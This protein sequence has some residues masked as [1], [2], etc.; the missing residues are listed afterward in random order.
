MSIAIRDLV[1]ALVGGEYEAWYVAELI[2]ARN[3]LVTGEPA[4]PLAKH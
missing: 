2:A 4:I 1:D 3:R